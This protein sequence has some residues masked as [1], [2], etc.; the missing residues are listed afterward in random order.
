MKLSSVF[1]ATSRGAPQMKSETGPPWWEG[2]ERP[3]KTQTSPD[4]QVAGGMNAK[5]SVITR[6][7]LEAAG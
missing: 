5:G 1:F 7:V 6:L 4:W 3:R 2:K